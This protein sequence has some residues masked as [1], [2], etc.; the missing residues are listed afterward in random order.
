MAWNPISIG[1]NIF[2]IVHG[3]V[4]DDQAKVASSS[5]KLGVSAVPLAGFIPGLG[6]AVQGFLEPLL[7]VGAETLADIA[8]GS[9]LLDVVHELHDN[10]QDF[11]HHV[12]LPTIN[13]FLDSDDDGLPDI[14]GLSQTIAAVSGGRIGAM[15]LLV[16]RM[17]E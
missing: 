8:S 16:D 3:L 11:Q 6:D 4:N 7:G 14:N 17:S 13:Q 5:I 10:A 15:E 12:P 9:P 1:K 2:G